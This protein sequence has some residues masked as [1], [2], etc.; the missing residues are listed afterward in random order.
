MN[1]PAETTYY[2]RAKQLTM[3]VVTWLDEQITVHI[4]LDELT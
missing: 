2:G 4:L 3:G 1:D